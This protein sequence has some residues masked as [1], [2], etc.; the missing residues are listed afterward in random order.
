[1]TK[2]EMWEKY[3]TTGNTLIC[4][5]CKDYCNEYLLIE[6][7]DEKLTICKMCFKYEKW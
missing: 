4:D 7:C 3:K 6:R 5:E 1:M 2:K